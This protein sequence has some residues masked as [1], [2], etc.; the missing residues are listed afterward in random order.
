MFVVIIQDFSMFLL[1]LP[2]KKHNKIN[3]LGDLLFCC[4]TPIYKNNHFL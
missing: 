1:I 2:M 3:I 4:E